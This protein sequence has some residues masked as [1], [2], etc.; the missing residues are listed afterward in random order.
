[1]QKVWRGHRALGGILVAAVAFAVGAAPAGAAV[2]IGQLG[3]ASSSACKTNQN[4]VQLGVAAGNGYAVPGNGTITSWTMNGAGPTAQ[5]FTMMIYRTLAD[6]SAT[7]KSIEVVGH[8]GPQTV[9]P[10]GTAGNTFPAN[11]P[12]KTGDLLGLRV[13]G[14]TINAPCAVLVP[15]NTLGLFLGNPADGDSNT[16]TLSTS[17]QGLLD[18]E[19]TFMPDN[20]FSRTGK[21]QRNKKAGTA[22]LAFNLPNPGTL[23]GAGSGAKVAKDVPAGPTTVKV[24]AKGAKRRTLNQFG[25]VVV[26]PKITYTPGGG[27]PSTQRFKVKLLKK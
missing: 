17:N 24:K 23:T 4:F 6:I 20:T 26:K 21:I 2:T 9:T 11:V 22:T 19:A 18:V 27:D 3:D 8:A 1:M 13:D 14:M 25:K 15:G 5:Q 16:Y 7:Q 10:G 12:V